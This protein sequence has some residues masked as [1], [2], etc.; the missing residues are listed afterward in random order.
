M[1]LSFGGFSSISKE[2]YN[3]VAES[4][5]SNINKHTV[6]A[7]VKK[8]YSNGRFDSFTENFNNRNLVRQ[9]EFSH[10]TYQEINQSS[11][12]PLISSY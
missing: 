2:S 5:N 10:L 9:Y 3:S 4:V 6:T 7:S 12:A 1:S 8:K 11:A